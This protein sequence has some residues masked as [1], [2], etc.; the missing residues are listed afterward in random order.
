MVSYQ[1]EESYSTDLHT[2][3]VA[4]ALPDHVVIFMLKRES[5]LTKSKLHWLT[6][7]HMQ[8]DKL[9]RSLKTQLKQGEPEFERLK[10]E[11]EELKH[12]Q[13]GASR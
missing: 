7:E 8:L 9:V 11:L 4:S 3:E 10:R 5:L 13:R 1:G 12:A 6:F 2:E